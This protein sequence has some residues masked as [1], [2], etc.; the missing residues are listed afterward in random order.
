MKLSNIK[1]VLLVLSLLIATP[2]CGIINRI[3]AKN[4]LNEGAAAYKARKFSEAQWHFERALQFDPSQKSAP[5][6][7]ARSIHAQYKP[8]IETE[9]NLKKAKDAI[10]AYQKVLA[11]DPNNDEAYNAV[12]YL[13]GAIK[14]DTSQRDWITKR[15]NLENAPK[16]KRSEAYTVLASKEWDC[17]Y[18]ITE[19]QENKQTVMKDNKAIIQFKKPKE[20]KDFDAAKQCVLKGLELVEKA[21][22]LNDKNESAWSYKTNL[23][24]E[25][26]KLAEMDGKPDDK[27]NYSKQADIAQTRTT[28]L[29]EENR[30]RR[31]EEAAKKQAQET[32]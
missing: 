11:N 13:Y 8:G 20:Q 1:T 18:K 23:L 9:E 19:A 3:R 27:T 7:I 16:E 30:K 2:G 5:F 21:I 32:S 6:F 28:E 24:R 17:S 31:E 4:E 25:M 10:N 22:S 29:S 12:A 26:A 14:D 15:A